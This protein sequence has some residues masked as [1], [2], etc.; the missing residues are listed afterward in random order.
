MKN[1]YFFIKDKWRNDTLTS[2]N[3][4][5]LEFG[6]GVNYKHFYLNPTVRLNLISNEINITPSYVLNNRFFVKGKLFKAK[7]MEAIFGVDV[8]YVSSYNTLDYNPV[9]DAFV[10]SDDIN[11]FKGYYSL[12][13][14]FGF[15]MGEFRMY[16]RIENMQYPF[17]DKT[18]Q[19]VTGY[20]VQPNFVRLGV[21]WDFFN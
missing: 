17:V 16:A 1:N 7:K 10:F 11:R 5:T 2:I 9:V 19:V 8:S 13:T 15:E 14:Y 6:G 20:P 12:S 21:T 3:M 18:N 4:Q